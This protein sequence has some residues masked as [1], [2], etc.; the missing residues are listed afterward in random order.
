M[1][2]VPVSQ[3]MA[4]KFPEWVGLLV[5]RDPDAGGKPNVMPVGWIMCCAFEPPMIALAVGNARYTHQVLMKSR[6]FVLAFA[7][8]GQVN[9][10][11]QA[12]SGSGRDEDKFAKYGIP[13]E[14]GALTGCPLLTEAAINLECEVDG[15]LVAGDHTIFSAKILAAYL[16]DRPIRKIENFGNNRLAPA[17]PVT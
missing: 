8:E 13:H 7:G 3:A 10:V 12:G 1:K 9:L 15:T 4:M 6:K 17:V 11:Q 2:R 5:V 16:P 14:N